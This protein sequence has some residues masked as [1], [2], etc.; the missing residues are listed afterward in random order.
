MWTPS[1]PVEAPAQCLHAQTKIAET[2]SITIMLPLELCSWSMAFTVSCC[3]ECVLCLHMG[4]RPLEES[5]W[6]QVMRQCWHCRV[7]VPVRLLRSNK[8]SHHVEGMCAFADYYEK[9]QP[10]FKIDSRSTYTE[11]SHLLDTCMLDKSRRTVHGRF[12]KLHPRAYPISM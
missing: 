7:S 9:N 10:A 4:Q 12:R 11:D 6:I 3:V 1:Q 8:L 5:C 2:L